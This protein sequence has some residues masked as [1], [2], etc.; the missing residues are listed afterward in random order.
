MK[1]FSLAYK[2]IL[3][4]SI[5]ILS[6]VSII[7]A[8]TFIEAETIIETQITK[9]LTAIAEA[10]EGQIFMFFEKT[11]TLSSNWSSD[12]IIRQT[13]E[14]IV[15]NG[16]MSEV[17]RLNN[18]L[19]ENKLPLDKTVAIADILNIEMYVIASSDAKRIGS[20]E[21]EHQEGMGIEDLI[22]MRYGESMISSVRLEEGEDHHPNYPVFHALSPIKSPAGETLGF[23]LLHFAS[24]ELDKIVAGEWQVSQGALSGQE[25]IF[26][27]KTSEMFLVNRDNFMI[28]QSRF[29][30]DSVLK[31]K[32]DN[33]ATR[34]CFDNN[35][36]YEGSYVGY[37]GREV[38]VSTMCFV[39]YDMV[40][41]TEIG[42]E[43][44]FAPL[45]EERNDSILLGL[46][47]W[48][49]SMIVTFIFASFSLGKIKI[50]T[51]VADEVAKNNFSVRVPVRSNDE[52][53]VLSNVF[54]VMLDNIEKSKFDLENINQQL[55]ASSED[56]EKLAI[57][58]EGKVKSRTIELEDIKA[59]LELRVHEKTLELQ[60]RLDELE[61]F[62]RLT[63]GRELRMIELKEEIALLKMKAEEGKK[64][65]V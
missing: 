34:A 29:K 36:E 9:D 57:S 54:N 1:Q 8:Y 53:G 22:A 56:L 28:T 23:M 25:F 24:G 43:E 3:F 58:L 52:I 60:K 4:F 12:G 16:E 38:Y 55:Q 47:V 30:E 51:K 37:L 10:T 65:N 59:N 6:V 44:I 45:I 19:V 35:E 40:L 31:Q 18:H 13:V 61:K 20:L 46:V 49:L 5:L 62:R 32:V 14:A 21:E 42:T 39:D 7:V 33:P 11:K 15:K 50:I 64:N 17:S 26:N 2:I 27:Q 63:M 48:I 41:L